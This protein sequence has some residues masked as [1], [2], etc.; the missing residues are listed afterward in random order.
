MVVR[1]I[2]AHISQ[3]PAHQI[4]YFNLLK[5]VLISFIRTAQIVLTVF[6]ALVTVE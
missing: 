1:V 6:I 3:Q 2:I 4:N 5:K